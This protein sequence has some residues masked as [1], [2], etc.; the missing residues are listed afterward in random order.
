MHSQIEWLWEKGKKGKNTHTYDNCTRLGWNNSKLPF[1]FP[2]ILPF[3]KIFLRPPNFFSCCSCVINPFS[4][5][6][7]L[8]FWWRVSL[9]GKIAI[10]KYLLFLLCLFLLFLHQRI[11]PLCVI[12]SQFFRFPFINLSLSSNTVEENAREKL[13]CIKKNFASC[14]RKTCL[15]FQSFHTLILRL[16]TIFF[17]VS[18]IT[19]FTCHRKKKIR[20]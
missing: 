8:I 13:L 15:L 19:F 9:K 17:F 7:S 16:A 10:R 3:A 6:T 4:L 1:L 2:E 18:S 12:F 5:L 20:N 14:I 11:F